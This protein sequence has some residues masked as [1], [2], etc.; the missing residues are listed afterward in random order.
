MNRLCVRPTTGGDLKPKRHEQ[1]LLRNMGVHKVCTECLKRH[2]QRLLRNMGV[3]KVCTEC[4]KRHEQRLLRNMGVHKVCTESLKRHE[5]RL[6]RNMVVY[7]VCTESLKVM[8]LVLCPYNCC[9]SHGHD[10][11]HGPWLKS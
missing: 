8:V 3:H 2:E 9:F 1:R 11:D 7:K 5:Q 10:N 6:L 4:L